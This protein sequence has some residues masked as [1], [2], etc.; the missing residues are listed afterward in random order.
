MKFLAGSLSC[1]FGTLG[2]VKA[3][4]FVREENGFTIVDYFLA[5]YP[6]EYTELDPSNKKGYIS[7]PKSGEKFTVPKDLPPT[8]S[9]S[10]K[11]TDEAEDL[12]SSTEENEAAA[13]LRMLTF[14][15]VKDLSNFPMVSQAVGME[16]ALK[17]SI[18]SVVKTFV[19]GDFLAPSILSWQPD[20]GGAG[21]MEGLKHAGVDYFS[22][23]NHEFDTEVMYNWSKH[24]LNK[25]IL[26][27]KDMILQ[28]KDVTFLN[29]NLMTAKGKFQKSLEVDGP[30]EHL[31]NNAEK[32]YGSPFELFTICNTGVDTD[33]PMI[34][35]LV[36]G[37]VS[38]EAAFYGT[39]GAEFT[40]KGVKQAVVDTWEAAKETLNGDAPEVFV[41]MVHQSYSADIELAKFILEHPELRDRVP[42]ILA[43]SSDSTVRH[44]DV[45]DKTIKEV[46]K[47]SASPMDKVRSFLQLVGRAKERVTGGRT[48]SSSSSS[49]DQH[50]SL[51]GADA[52]AA[53]TAAGLQ[54]GT[55]MNNPASANSKKD[56]TSEL[57]QGGA[58]KISIIRPGEDAKILGMIDLLF[59]K[60]TY[61]GQPKLKYTTKVA[62]IEYRATVSSNAGRAQGQGATP[63]TKYY[64]PDP[65]DPAIQ[66][67]QKLLD[68][69][70]EITENEKREVIFKIT[71]NEAGSTDKSTVR[72]NFDNGGK[73]AE[74]LAE[75]I[76]PEQPYLDIESAKQQLEYQEKFEKLHESNMV[77][78]ILKSIKAGV[79]KELANSF[80]EKAEKVDAVLLAG[81]VFK[82]MREYKAG[83]TMTLFDMKQELSAN[84]RVRIVDIP[85]KILWETIMN[86]RRKGARGGE[87]LHFYL[88]SGRIKDL[89]GNGLKNKN[90]M[91]VPFLEMHTGRNDDRLFKVVMNCYM[92]NSLTVEP[93]RGYNDLILAT[94]MMRKEPG[95]WGIGPI[96]NIKSTKSFCNM[97]EK[98]ETTIWNG[99]VARVSDPD[100]KKYASIFDKMEN[101]FGTR[102]IMHMIYDKSRMFNWNG[103]ESLPERPR[104]TPQMTGFAISGA[105]ILYGGGGN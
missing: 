47:K 2:L 32:K 9:A 78:A 51:L 20:D 94:D 77:T 69:A 54:Q 71:E 86:S 59:F 26:K 34:N 12:G 97:C 88:D 24:V 36:A 46:S 31:Y 42:V 22:L 91:D 72:I 68:R 90:N 10:T 41:I 66:G 81:G 15:N 8:C 65:N 13:A 49:G 60:N 4:P 82:S 38:D 48:A 103:D 74:L 98:R 43:A 85:G 17:R 62:D 19:P 50:S 101:R 93:L 25:D 55:A 30:V 56:I 44:I 18:P 61:G 21:M 105:K 45:L 6:G 70:E 23:G 84:H 67:I 33:L 95:S 58:R 40:L 76:T 16:K 5:T 100:F 92:F 102:G 104:G 52:A 79:D 35:V 14:S 96:V 37:F 39:Q 64:E 1:L 87:L 83:E 28:T 57:E 80:G 53:A 89:A 27:T 7:V 73:D 11:K 99:I 29:G 63:V 75:C 3:F